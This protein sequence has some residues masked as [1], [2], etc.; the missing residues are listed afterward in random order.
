MRDSGD[1]LT[2]EAVESFLKARRDL[3]NWARSPTSFM[4]ARMLD[5]KFPT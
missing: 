5:Y 3:M 2:K 4:N 1:P